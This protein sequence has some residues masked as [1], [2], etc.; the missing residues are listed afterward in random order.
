MTIAL[1][2]C[3]FIGCSTNISTANSTDNKSEIKSQ[4]DSGSNKD[5]EVAPNDKAGTAN[6]TVES[7]RKI[8]ISHGLTLD[9]VKGKYNPD[10]SNYL[11]IKTVTY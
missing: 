9:D 10:E 1:I 6:D 5:P 11:Y 4:M 8:S 7:M 3:S 2:I